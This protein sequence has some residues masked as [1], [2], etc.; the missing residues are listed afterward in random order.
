VTDLGERIIAGVRTEGV[1]ITFSKNA[2]AIQTCWE[3]RWY[4]Q[5]LGIDLLSLHKGV[6]DVLLVFR[7]TEVRFDDPPPSVFQYPSDFG[8]DRD[9][10]MLQGVH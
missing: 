6:D 5:E 2:C 3:E 7:V 10:M 8:I 1:R 4:S 9:S